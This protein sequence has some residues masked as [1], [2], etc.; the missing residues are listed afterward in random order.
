MASSGQKQGACGHVTGILTSTLGVH[1]VGRMDR[2]PTSVNKLDCKCCNMLTAD[3]IAQL[4]I[5]TYKARKDMK[6]EKVA[7]NPLPSRHRQCPGTR[8]C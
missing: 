7:A 8:A 4:F 5:P 2:V 6:S 1:V 3:Q